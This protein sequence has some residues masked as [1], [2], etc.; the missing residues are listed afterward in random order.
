[1]SAADRV[2]VTTFSLIILSLPK[3][4]TKTRPIQ[5]KKTLTYCLQGAAVVVRST[6][7]S[8]HEELW[9]SS[10][11]IGNG[12]WKNHSLNLTLMIYAFFS[13]IHYN[14]LNVKLLILG[15]SF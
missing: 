1:M 13:G 12:R 6:C 15:V 8:G 11:V 2:V 7:N 9:S 3:E 14:Q 10:S 4:V 5:K